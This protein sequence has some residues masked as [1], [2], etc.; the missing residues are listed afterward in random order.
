MRMKYERERTERN[1]CSRECYNDALSDDVAGEDN[2]NWRGGY[3]PYYGPE[4][5]SQ[6]RKA[7]QRDDYECQSC[8]LSREQNREQWDKDLEV[9]HIQPIRTFADTSEANQLSNLITL[10]TECHTKHEH[11][12]PTVEPT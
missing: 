12:E 1:F 9:H 11:D 4:W 6:R 7:L 10:C 8:G 2:F 5:H 3:E